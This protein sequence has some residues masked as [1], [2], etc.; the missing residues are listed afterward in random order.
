ATSE[1][2]NSIANA[3]TSDRFGNDSI[4]QN[5]FDSEINFALIRLNLNPPDVD[6]GI[7]KVPE[8]YTTNFQPVD[9]NTCPVNA[10]KLNQQPQA[11]ETA[12]GKIYPARGIVA[13]NGQINLTAKPT[14]NTS[15]RTYSE[16]ESCL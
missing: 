1:G 9:L 6:Y 8:I 10:D 16:L 11:I 12:Q 7:N 3:S 14:K 2:E 4:N 5:T 15:R 13:E